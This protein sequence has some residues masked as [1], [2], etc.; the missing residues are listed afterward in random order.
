MTKK[1][2]ALMAVVTIIFVC[3]FAACDKA[4]YTNPAT[5]TKYELVT[6]E[7]GEKVFS[8]D[9]ELIVYS[10]DENG[11]KIK[12]ENGEYVTQKQAFIGQIE[13]N[14]VVEDYAYYLTLPK[15]WKTTDTFGTFERESKKQTIEIDIVE[16]TY[17]DY[18][19]KCNQL[20]KD[21]LESKTEGTE[22]TWEGG[23]S[24]AGGTDDAY[25]M[26]CQSEDSTIV[27]ITF[28]RSG[29]VYNVRLVDDGNKNVEEARADC[30]A[31]CNNLN[32]K[33]YVYYPELTTESTTK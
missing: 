29:N 16:H 9:G 12:D 33:P 28:A 15:G 14:G 2:I 7:N 1:I 19:E 5:G 6:D 4:T 10:I 24:V 8:D 25:M 32:F 30:I 13:E 11:D 27:A 20:Y 3:T 23:I 18:V 21:L 17:E 31:F 26:T 22:C